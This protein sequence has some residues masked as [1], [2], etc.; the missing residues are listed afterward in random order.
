VNRLLTAACAT[1]LVVPLSACS[2]TESNKSAA[3]GGQGTINV[4]SSADK[5]DLTTAKAPSGNVVFKVKNTGNEVT[6]F[7]LYGEDGMRI[8]GEIENVGPGLSRDLV[9]RAAPGKYVTACKPGMKGQGIRDAFTV[10]DSGKNLQIKGVDQATIDQATAQYAAYVRDQSQELEDQATQFVAAYESGD[11][12]KARELFPHARG[13][14]ERIEPVA[15]SFGDLD[16]ELD[17]READLEKGQE[18]T[19]WHRIEK[20]LWPPGKGYRTLDSAGRKK[21]GDNLLANTKKLN[22][23]VQKLDYT[24]D[25]IGNG[26]K[27]LL[28]EVAASKITGEEDT[29]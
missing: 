26:S 6:E 10:S 18:W 29:W 1:V 16:P 11:A 2:L 12:A 9:V 25:Q 24:V 7:Y 20:D 15:E 27:G 14:Y 13:H 5:C 23:R 21:Y 22:A 4:E 28:D 8:V 17:L 3:Q 19:G